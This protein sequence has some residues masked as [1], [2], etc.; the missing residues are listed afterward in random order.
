MKP[1]ANPPKRASARRSLPRARSLRLRI[2]TPRDIPLLVAHRLSMWTD[3]GGRTP[4]AIHRHGAVY[5]R[6]LAKRIRSGEL[7]TFIAECDGVIAGSGGVW[8]HSA[9]P[10]PGEEREV[11]P[12][13]L[14]MY[15]V[16]QFRGFG[17]ASSIVRRLVDLCRKR[18]FARVELHASVQGQPVY[19]RL[20]FER[21]REM[22]LWLRRP[23]SPNPRPRRGAARS[24]R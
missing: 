18:G 21:T 7:V 11:C 17:V 2:A 15:T 10:R 13:I 23:R 9:Q 3:I 6:W 4:R 16:P 12:Y 14:S 5:R 8:F 24:A 1:G 19:R 20:G 22:R